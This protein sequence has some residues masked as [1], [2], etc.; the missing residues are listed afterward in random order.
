MRGLPFAYLD[1]C[2]DYQITEDRRKRSFL[3]TGVLDEGT[4]GLADQEQLDDADL[5][6]H[7][8]AAG[9]SSTDSHWRMPGFRNN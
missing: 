9:S 2:V 4:P 3:V 5:P 6:S 8:S 7:S 1:E